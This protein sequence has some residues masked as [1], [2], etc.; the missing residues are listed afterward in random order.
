MVKTLYRQEPESKFLLDAM[1]NMAID[2]GELEEYKSAAL[3]YKR[4]FDQTED[5]IRAHDALYNSSLFF[6]QGE[7]WEEAIETNNLFV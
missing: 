1:N 2:Y 6:V 3:T 5:S 7:Y 4:L